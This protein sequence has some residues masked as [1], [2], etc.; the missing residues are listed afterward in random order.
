MADEKKYLE[1]NYDGEPVQQA[2]QMAAD[3]V[4]A[5]KAQ[6]EI[7]ETQ[8]RAYEIFE[9]E[10]IDLKGITSEE[11]ERKM[12]SVD[13]NDSLHQYL[14]D[15][16]LLTCTMATLDD[17]E[18]DSETSVKLEIETLEEGE[19]RRQTFLSVMEN[20]MYI[21]ESCYATVKDTI[22]N[23]NI[24]PFRCNCRQKAD[25]MSEIERI[26]NNIADCRE[27]GVCQYLI[28]L[29]EEW[30]NM[31]LNDGKTYQRH[32]NI[33][34]VDSVSGAGWLIGGIDTEI[35]D[36]EGI[37]RTSVLFCKHGG[38]IV[39]LTSGQ[40]NTNNLIVGV[41]DKLIELLKKYETG[42]DKYGNILP[43]GD[44]A[45]YP[46][47]APSDAS[48]VLTIGWGHAMESSNDGW[49]LFS[50]GTRIN[51]YDMCISDKSGISQINNITYDQAVE[52]LQSDI[53]IRK[54]KLNQVLEDKNINTMVN[55]RFYDALFLLTY[56]VGT[57]Y[58][59]NG[60]NLSN[61]LEESNFDPTNEQEIKEQFGEFTNHLE[62][63]TMRRRADEL[64]IIF[65]GTY[66]RESDEKRYG[67]IWR[68][69]TYPNVTTP[70][71]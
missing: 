7:R 21:G 30:D 15:G 37:T 70:G 60:S 24:F 2:V 13:K 53:E 39:P 18:V 50:D 67:D 10:C 22:I 17:F 3:V 26:K 27:N 33:K 19:K 14:V 41:S 32:R 62:I 23:R 38:L 16:A 40:E 47:H 20:A 25:R 28:C 9:D 44:P 1:G 11:F 43:E 46:Y 29:N 48:N 66:E 36:V 12:E 58:L 69:K 68:K 56:Q 63:G 54:E 31:L 49:F 4:R 6:K 52:I 71:Y 42:L 61:F 35:E 34:A 57:G 5:N 51:L 59:T 55:Q 45:L 8:K 64:D 65:D